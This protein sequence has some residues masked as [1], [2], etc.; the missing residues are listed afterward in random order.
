[1]PCKPDGGI[2]VRGAPSDNRF[3]PGER[4]AERYEIVRPLSSG[5]MGA[6]YEVLQLNLGRRRALKVLHSHSQANPDLRRRFM[7][8][9]KVIARV[10]SDHVV[11]VI[12]SG[13]A[14]P[15]GSPYLV[16]ELLDGE[17]LWALLDSEGSLE[18]D[19]L[20]DFA[21]Q[22]SL[23]IEKLHDRQIVHRDLKPSNLF[24]TTRDDGRRHITLIDF[25]IAKSLSA[26]P[27]RAT[28]GILGTPVYLSPE[29]IHGE[30][31]TSFAT[32]RYAL[33]HV[34]YT[35]AT[36]EPYF[37]QEKK[38]AGSEPYPL[39]MKIVEG[40]R[41]APVARAWRR[42]G[43]ELPTG[44]DAW[45]ETATA[46]DPE[47]RFGSMGAMIVALAD[48]LGVERPAGAKS[49][50]SRR[51]MPTLDSR[52]QPQLTLV[53]A[54]KNH[55]PTLV[56]SV[57]ESQPEVT[58]GAAQAELTSHDREAAAMA[59]PLDISPDTMASAGLHAPFGPH[60]HWAATAVVALATA[61][62]AWW[63]APASTALRSHMPAMHASTFQATRYRTPAEAAAVDS[64][65]GAHANGT[66]AKSHA[67]TGARRRAGSGV[68]TARADTK[69]HADTTTARA[70]TDTARADAKT[71][72]VR[73]TNTARTDAKSRAPSSEET[74][75]AEAKSLA[76]SN[77][78]SHAASNAQI[79]AAPQPTASVRA[80]ASGRVARAGPPSAEPTPSQRR[81]EPA[82]IRVPVDFR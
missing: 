26:Q 15:T 27:A 5:G 69:T 42:R 75:R 29:Q 20:V 58:G 52:P 53:R 21:W 40:P 54:E 31:P 14:E 18:A 7:D 80:R 41:E 65:H 32:D 50:P 82:K 10:E 35:L 61:A 44:F 34:V 64:G 36:G 77:A 71:R 57:P 28:T 74:T 25:G 48:S 81:L 39:L 12:D 43:V 55:D 73:N 33:A 49:K 30:V 62:F 17:D 46:T 37:A 4:F 8:E 78:S 59:E 38:E 22:A 51:S 16:M 66:L 67:P 47:Q 72:A 70:D 2:D 19:T 23:A 56:R 68:K 60:M 9:A 1:M 13:I 11:E 79:P 6:V 3:A 76:S 45:F 24:V 63:T